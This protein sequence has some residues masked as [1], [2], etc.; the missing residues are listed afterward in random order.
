[1]H[2]EKLKDE[3]ISLLAVSLS[4]GNCRNQTLKIIA[5]QAENENYGIITTVNV[6]KNLCLRKK[7]TSAIT[8]NAK[9]S[10]AEITPNNKAGFQDG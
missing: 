6:G 2:G 1:M 4:R 3:V 8:V 10:E 9:V 5:T 7:R